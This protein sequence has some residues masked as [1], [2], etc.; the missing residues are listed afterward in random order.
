MKNNTSRS[1]SNFYRTPYC[2]NI[3]MLYIEYDFILNYTK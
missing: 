3:P 2:L 1:A